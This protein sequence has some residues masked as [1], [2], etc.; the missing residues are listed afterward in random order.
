MTCRQHTPLSVSQRSGALVNQ[1]WERLANHDGASTAVR[2]ELELSLEASCTLVH[3]RC[4]CTG[5]SPSGYGM[6]VSSTGKAHAPLE[7]VSRC[8]TGTVSHVRRIRAQH[9]TRMRVCIRKSSYSMLQLIN[10]AMNQQQSNFRGPWTAPVQ[11]LQVVRM[12]D[13][14][15]GNEKGGW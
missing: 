9:P 3:V 15:D 12:D 4:E 1:D 6:S 11:G 5:A 13:D 8:G 2:L 7:G 14:D 10:L